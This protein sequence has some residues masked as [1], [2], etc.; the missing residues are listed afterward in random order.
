[1]EPLSS[2]LPVTSSD[3]CLVCVF[4]YV[5]VNPVHMNICIGYFALG[6]CVN[7]PVYVNKR[8]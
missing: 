3:G 1:M 5:V 2:Y 4:V 7:I 8:L 6:I